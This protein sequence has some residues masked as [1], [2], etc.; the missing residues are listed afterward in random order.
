MHYLSF[1]PLILA[2]A[3]AALFLAACA[4]DTPADSGDT[5]L[6]PTPTVSTPDSASTPSTPTGATDATD[7]TEG[8]DGID[9]EAILNDAEQLRILLT[10]AASRFNSAVDDIDFMDGVLTVTLTDEVTGLSDAEDA[11]ED[12]S[13]AIAAPDIEIVVVDTAGSTL[14]QCQFTA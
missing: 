5:A 12:I 2:F 9:R 11:C 1:R 10:S 4:E 6:M 13:Q 8:S 3:G 7:A 14:A